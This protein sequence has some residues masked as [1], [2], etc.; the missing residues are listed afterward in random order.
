VDLDFSRI[1]LAYLINARDIARAIPDRAPVLLGVADPLGQILA[2]LTADTL[3]GM[4]QIKPP[5]LVPRQ[6][7]WWWERLLAAIHAQ[8]PDAVQDVL[9]HAGLLMADET[10]R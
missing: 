2:G 1:N 10:G 8:C 6:E 4:S 7:P 3:A 5:L 9:D